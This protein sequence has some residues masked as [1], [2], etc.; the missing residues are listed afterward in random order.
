MKG[1]IV[2]GLEGSCDL[3]PQHPARIAE[4][5]PEGREAA[6]LEIAVDPARSANYLR[7]STS[8]RSAPIQ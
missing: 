1:L 4:V 6:A 7:R 3:S 8:V 5:L 2:Q